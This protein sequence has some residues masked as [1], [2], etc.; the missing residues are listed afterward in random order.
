MS[1]DN[2]S[3]AARCVGQV[4][5]RPAVRI[6]ESGEDVVK[7]V[8]PNLTNVYGAGFNSKYRD[9]YWNET[10]YRGPRRDLGGSSN[11]GG[12]RICVLRTRG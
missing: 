7:D 10:T 9:G 2:V 8:R 4:G 12:S 11:A 3:F 5:R 1:E 6:D